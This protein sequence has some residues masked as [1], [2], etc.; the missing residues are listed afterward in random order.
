MIYDELAHLFE[1]L[2]NYGAIFFPS[3]LLRA[4]SRRL[5]SSSDISVF[6]KSLSILNTNSPNLSAS[7]GDHVW[8]APSHDPP[9]II[10]APN[11]PSQN[12]AAQ[13]N[14]S[15]VP[16]M[17]LTEPQYQIFFFILTTFCPFFQ[18][19]SPF[20]VQIPAPADLCRQQVFLLVNVF[21]SQRH[22]VEFCPS[23]RRLLSPLHTVCGVNSTPKM[24]R[25]I[26]RWA[27]P[28]SV[29][30]LLFSYRENDLLTEASCVT[31]LRTHT[32]THTSWS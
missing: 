18:Y 3:W 9:A 16:R 7:R 31:L 13:K 19:P 27:V 22:T 11:C 6:F 26:P 21:H 15:N 12:Q 17:R 23:A 2:W 25:G 10:P 24:F 32:H 1:A 29:G 14:R 8:T 28:L 4:G 20:S 30:C 5:H